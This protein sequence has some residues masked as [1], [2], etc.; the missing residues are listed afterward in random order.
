[1]VRGVLERTRGDFTTAVRQDQLQDALRNL[2]RKLGQPDGPDPRITPV[3]TSGE[4]DRNP[5]E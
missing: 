4:C 1:M 5:D 3:D 2:E